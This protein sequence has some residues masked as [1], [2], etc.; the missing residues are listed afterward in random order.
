MPRAARL[1]LLFGS[2]ADGLSPGALEA[3]D[4]VCRIPMSAE[5]TSL[6]VAVASAV[7]LY[8]AARAR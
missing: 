2:E 3:C 5:T 4:V 8:E 6:N 7:F 1:G